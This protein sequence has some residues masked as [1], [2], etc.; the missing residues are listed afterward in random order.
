MQV[1]KYDNIA[2]RIM[3]YWTK[4]YSG[5]IREGEGYEKLHKTIVILITDFELDVTKDIP[6]FH[7]E[8]K[9]RETEYSKIVLTNVLEIHIIELPKVENKNKENNKLMVWTKFLKTPEEI[10]DEDMKENEEVKK[11]KEELDKIKQDKRERELA[12]LRLKYI[13]D[14]KA[15]QSYGFRTGEEKGMKAGMEKGMKKG[16]K[17][18]KIRN[19]KKMLELNMPI[20]QIKQ[21]TGLSQDEIEKINK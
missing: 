6:K 3:Y 12:E 19:A 16:I 8:W 15:I 4:L 14:Q 13:R 5:D 7:T 17:E 21:I 11:A 20:E 1:V 9:I 18:E 10:G 2:N